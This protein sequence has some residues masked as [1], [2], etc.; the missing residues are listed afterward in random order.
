MFFM[1]TKIEMSVI[2]GPFKAVIWLAAILLTAWLDMKQT[3]NNHM[4]LQLSAYFDMKLQIKRR[5]IWPGIVS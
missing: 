5:K 4:L 3:T 1:N 2:F